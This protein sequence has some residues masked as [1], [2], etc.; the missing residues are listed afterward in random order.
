MNNKTYFLLNNSSLKHDKL[1]FLFSF[2][3]ISGIFLILILINKNMII[4]VTDNILYPSPMTNV[5]SN[6]KNLYALL[7][8]KEIIA[9]LDGDTKYQEYKFADGTTV[10][11]SMP[12]LRGQDLCD[13]SHIVWL[14]NV[15]FM[16]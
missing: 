14:A 2:V 12:Y 15:L 3:L 16:G 10:P 9:I 11:V 4:F 1:I 7:K 13:V 8:T 5:K 6:E